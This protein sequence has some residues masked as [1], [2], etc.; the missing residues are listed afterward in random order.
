MSCLTLAYSSP[1]QEQR[2]D[3]GA[4]PGQWLRQ[5]GLQKCC[6]DKGGHSRFVRKTEE[7]R[8]ARRPAQRMSRKDGGLWGAGGQL[9]WE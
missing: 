2:V 7:P 9:W 8:G 4:D 6:G 1:A 3:R 5:E